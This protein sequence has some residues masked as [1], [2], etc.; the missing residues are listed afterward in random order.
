MADIHNSTKVSKRMRKFGVIEIVF[1]VMQTLLLGVPE[2]HLPDKIGADDTPLRGHEGEAFKH[3]RVPYTECDLYFPRDGHQPS[4]SEA[5]EWS[6]ARYIGGNDEAVRD[7]WVRVFGGNE[8]VETYN[9]IPSGL[10]ARC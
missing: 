10:A 7:W 1:C 8:A 2:F 5:G 6:G 3:V 4:T 9:P